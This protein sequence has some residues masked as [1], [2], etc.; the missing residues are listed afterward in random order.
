MSTITLH[1]G[2]P[3]TLWLVQPWDLKVKS[4]KALEQPWEERYTLES[5]VTEFTIGAGPVLPVDYVDTGKPIGDV[6]MFVAS[7]HGG[8][9]ALQRDHLM[10]KAEDLEERAASVRARIAEV[11]ALFATEEKADE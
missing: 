1:P 7:S 11:E 8:A 2:N 5:W 9:I 4:V 3:V 6:S 10:R